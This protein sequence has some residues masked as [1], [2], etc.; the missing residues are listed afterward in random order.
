MTR[1]GVISQW[2][3]NLSRVDADAQVDTVTLEHI[4]VGV[5]TLRSRGWTSSLAVAP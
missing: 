3:G 5:E 2:H 1:S 4:S